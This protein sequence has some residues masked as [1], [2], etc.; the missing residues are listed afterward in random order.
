[1]ES[2]RKT[3]LRRGMALEGEIYWGETVSRV[4][5]VQVGQVLLK[6][7]RL[8][9]LRLR[10]LLPTRPS[11]C[12]LPNRLHPVDWGPAHPHFLRCRQP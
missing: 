3:K 6:V 9:R 10:L 4:S 5:R 12:P 1:M 2:R 7:R 8:H 11:H